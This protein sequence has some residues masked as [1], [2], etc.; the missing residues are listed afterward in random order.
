MDG[1]NKSQNIMICENCGKVVK[2]GMKTCPFCRKPVDTEVPDTGNQEQGRKYEEPKVI[3]CPVCGSKNTKRKHCFD[4]G[5]DFM[6]D[7]EQKAAEP[8]ESPSNDPAEHKHVSGIG[9]FIAVVLG[10]LVAIW[11]ASKIFE[12][13]VTGTITPMR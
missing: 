5:Y 1:Y 11:I 10:I 3:L 2:S 8:D 7:D 12:V 4:C 6:D 9:I 13:K